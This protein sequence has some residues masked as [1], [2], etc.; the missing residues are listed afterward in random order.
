M[1]STELNP[2]TS[3][4]KS[5]I[6]STRGAKMGFLVCFDS[7]LM[8]KDPARLLGKMKVVAEIFTFLESNSRS[9]CSINDVM[10]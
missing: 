7:L 10:P 9:T 6:L 2:A 4:A 3:S 8:R 1:L 5:S